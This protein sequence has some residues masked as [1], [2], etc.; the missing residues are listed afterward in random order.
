MSLC[1]LVFQSSAAWAVTTPISPSTDGFG[2]PYSNASLKLTGG[3][4]DTLYGLANVTRIDDSIDQWWTVSGTASAMAVAKFASYT[5]TLYAG[6][7]LLFTINSHGLNDPVTFTSADVGG[8]PF[9]FFDDPNGGSDPPK[10]SSVPGEKELPIN[11]D[12]L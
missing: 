8:G 3:I 5:Q 9:R 10:W 4:L 11:F 1:V 7:K 6:P 2:S 12:R